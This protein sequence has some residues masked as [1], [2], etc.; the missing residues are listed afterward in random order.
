MSDLSPLCCRRRCRSVGSG[1]ETLGSEVLEWGKK[2]FGCEINEFFGQTECN[3]VVSNSYTVFPIRPTSMGRVVP[4]H[5]LA[6]LCPESGKKLGP[7]Q[8]GNIGR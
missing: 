5:A 8:E 3:L 2:A 6:I 7:N 1:G 4:G